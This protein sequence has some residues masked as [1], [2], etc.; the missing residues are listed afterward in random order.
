M[1]TIFERPADLLQAVG[2]HL[3]YSQWLEID[4]ERIN[5]FADATLDHQF[6]HI[7][8]EKS[9]ELSPYKVTIAHGFLTLSLIV[10]LGA[11]IKPPR[12]EVGDGVF[13]G[14]NYGL[15]KVRFLAP[16]LV[17]ARVR[18]HI[19]LISFEKKDGPQYLMKCEN[20]LEI[21]RGEKPGLIAESLVML[22]EAPSA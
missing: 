3:G 4:Q 2:D 6:I 21:E 14:V 20:T 7:D 1:S 19:K 15:D 12:P 10:H 18:L 8:P 5:L 11:S 16:V 22:V 13:M 9:A 17:G